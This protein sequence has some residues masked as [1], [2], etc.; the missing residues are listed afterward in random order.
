VN[1][2]LPDV[3]G[4]RRCDVRL[5]ARD[6]LRSATVMTL[7]GVTTVELDEATLPAPGQACV[8][9]DG[10]RVLGGGIIQ[11]PDVSAYADRP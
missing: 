6:T 5:R 7:D 9:Y 1:W 11:R 4:A 2:L 8:F 10:S 3:P